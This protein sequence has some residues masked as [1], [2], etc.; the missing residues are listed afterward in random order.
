MRALTILIDMDDTLENFSE[1]L[2]QMLNE[3]HGLSADRPK[4]WDLKK[5]FPT[6]TFDEIWAPLKEDEFWERLTPLPGAVEYT[7]RLIE[8]GHKVR[9]VTATHPNNVEKKMNLMFLKHFPHFKY[10]DVIIAHEKQMINGDVLVDDAVHNH[11]GGKYLNI[12]FDASHNKEYDAAENGMIRADNWEKAYHIINN[13][14][15]PRR[16]R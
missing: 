9:I 2:V 1:I 15:N 16:I 11:I 10:K 12:L 6:L 13:Y 8:D 7:K 5:T 14:A 4:E 3:K